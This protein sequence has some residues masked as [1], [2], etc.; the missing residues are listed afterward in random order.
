MGTDFT[1]THEIRAMGRIF[2]VRIDGDSAYASDGAKVCTKA[3][4]GTWL[5][6]G[7]RVDYLVTRI[8][9]SI[10]HPREV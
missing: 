9:V 2:R 5:F 7:E 6:R 10:D 3:G 4:G 1:P 8:R